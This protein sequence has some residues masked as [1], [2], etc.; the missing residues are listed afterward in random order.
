MVQYG[1]KKRREEQTKDEEARRNGQSRGEWSGVQVI[2]TDDPE[3]EKSEPDADDYDNPG[4]VD[5]D[6]LP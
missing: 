6:E 1:Q 3:A 5:F 2:R 4:A